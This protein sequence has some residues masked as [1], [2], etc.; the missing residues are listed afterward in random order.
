M[1]KFKILGISLLLFVYFAANANTSN[2]NSVTVN[3]TE[4]NIISKYGKDSVQCVKELSLYR[5]FYKQWK[6]GKYKDKSLA[7]QT[8]KSWSYCFH[9]APIASKNMYIHGE[10]LSEFY[11]KLNKSDSLAQQSWVDTL[12]MIY[13]QRI[14]YY[15]D[16]PRRPEGMLIGR[17]AQ[18]CLKY[19]KYHSEQYYPAFQK[20]FQMMGNN[21]EARTLYYYFI[22]SIYY[23]QQGHGDRDLILENYVEIQEIID[24]N[25]LKYAEKPKKLIR[26]TK[27]ADNIEKNVKRFASCEKLIQLYGPKLEAS[28]E[29]LKLAKNIVRFFE[30]R[31]CTKNDTNDTY[32]NALKLVHSKEPNAESAFSMGKMAF[33]REQYPIAKKYL[34]EA[35][36]TLSDSNAVKKASAYL[37]LAETYRSLG[38]KSAARSAALNVLKYKPNEGMVYIIIGDLYTSSAA[39]CTLQGLRVAYWAA[40]DKYVKAASISKDDKIKEIAHKK[41]AVIK[42]SFPENQDLFMR[43]L[44]EGQ[45]I[46]VECWINENTTIRKR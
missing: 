24:Y 4:D 29:D 31:K 23:V 41:M 43:N 19:R 25:I 8:M 45:S 21:S 39:K 26:Y 37:L 7:D 22:A 6:A 30:A 16:D 46:K 3:S 12:L 38:Q 1:I 28:P 13:D 9:A 14:K 15:G 11:I 42:K 36:L 32:F 5:E 40:Y 2:A 35:A 27:V 44:K 17:K 20:S 18:M 34:E 33:E 10:K